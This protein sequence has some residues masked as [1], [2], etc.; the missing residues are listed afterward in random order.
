MGV[1]L[2]QLS[3]TGRIVAS[4]LLVDGSIVMTDEVRKRLLA[5]SGHLDAISHSVSR[6]RVPLIASALTT[7]LTFV[8][9][10]LIPGGPRRE[11]ELA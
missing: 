7:I 5:G 2:D 1:S 10:L 4:G 11:P 8:C 3:I 6:M 9:G